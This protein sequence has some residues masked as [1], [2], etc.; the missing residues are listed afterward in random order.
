MSLLK[1]VLVAAIVGIA[2]FLI[3]G[4]LH[5]TGLESGNSQVVGL[6]DVTAG[7]GWC[8]GTVATW[9]AGIVVLALIRERVGTDAA[10]SIFRLL[11]AGLYG[12]WILAVALFTSQLLRASHEHPTSP[13]NGQNEVAL[14]LSVVLLVVVLA[15]PM[16]AWVLAR[17][18]TRS[19]D[20]LP[21]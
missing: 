5:S 18:W 14:V 8:L 19:P 10:V 11:L 17:R 6:G 20:Q 3:G 21:A 12:V 7:R 4:A 9:F 13:S 2:L 15:A 16:A 1:G